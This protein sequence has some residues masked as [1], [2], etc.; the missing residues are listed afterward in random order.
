MYSL[1]NH[2]ENTE[3]NLI[4]SNEYKLFINSIHEFDKDC[5]EKEDLRIIFI[6]RLIFQ[7]NSILTNFSNDEN[8][9]ENIEK[10]KLLQRDLEFLSEESVK[11]FHSKIIESKKNN[12]IYLEFYK[13]IMKNK[14]KFLEIVKEDD[15]I[16][17]LENMQIIS[18]E[19]T[20]SDNKTILTFIKHFENADYQLSEKSKKLKEKREL[21]ENIQSVIYLFSYFF[22]LIK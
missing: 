4:R 20:Y 22:N 13:K 7:K 18:D 1:I 6:F 16:S 19:L 11:N 15:Q 5:L 17:V 21:F 10:I 3:I 8:S 12:I 14:G 9:D 2:A